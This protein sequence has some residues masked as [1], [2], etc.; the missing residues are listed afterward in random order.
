MQSTNSFSYDTSLTQ[1]YH[2]TY[3][4]GVSPYT[5][6]VGSFPANG[7]GLHDMAGNVWEWCWDW[8]GDYAASYQTDPHGPATSQY[9]AYRVLRGGC[10][11]DVAYY[12]RCAYRNGD[13]NPSNGLIYIGL[14]C[15]REL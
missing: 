2:P 4:D 15:V 12:T 9:A 6:P 8:Y 3:N 11:G 7:Y 5:S 14:R 10:W 13:N 1:G